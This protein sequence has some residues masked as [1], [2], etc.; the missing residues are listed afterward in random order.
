MNVIKGEGVAAARVAH[1]FDVRSGCM[2]A[3]QGEDEEGHGVAE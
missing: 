2:S 1:V 3:S